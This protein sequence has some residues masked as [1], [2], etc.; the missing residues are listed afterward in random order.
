MMV[1]EPVGIGRDE[2]PSQT[3]TSPKLTSTSAQDQSDE[4]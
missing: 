2:V 1:R 3:Q 4:G